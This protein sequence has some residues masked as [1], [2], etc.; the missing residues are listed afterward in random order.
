MMNIDSYLQ[1]IGF[2]G[3]LRADFES[4]C[5]IHAA[6][7]QSVPFENLDVQLGN[8]LT[9]DVLAAFGKIVTRRRGGWCY[10]QNAV[11]GWALAEAGFEVTRVAGA[12]MRQVRGDASAAS[13]LCLLVRTQDGPKTYLCDVGFGGSL[14]RPV[15]LAPAEH[16]SGPFAIQL[17]RLGD[18]W[19]RFEETAY[20]EA[21]SFDF[22]AEPADEAALVWKCGWLQSSPESSFVQNAVVQLRDAN[23]HYSLRGRVL[24]IANPQGRCKRVILSA[25]E[26]VEVLQEIFHLHAPG[27]ETLW[28]AIVARHDALGLSVQ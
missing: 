20:G 17:R 27:V 19:W 8:P 21:F 5:A 7:V 23:T 3:E 14:L 1:R 6:H 4:L 15:A 12:V 26:F 9:T 25:D 10:E 2:G 18:D 13:H 11:L 22:C 16:Q 24:T 28:P